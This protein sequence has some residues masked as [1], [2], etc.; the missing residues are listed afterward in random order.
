[1]TT[2]KMSHAQRQG[3]YWSALALIRLCHVFTCNCDRISCSLIKKKQGWLL[4][5]PPDFLKSTL[6][7][8]SCLLSFTTPAPEGV[9]YVE[10]YHPLVKGLARYILED[11]LSYTTE[12]IAARCGF[13]TT[14]AVQKRTTLLLIRLRH[15]LDSSKHTIETRNTTSLLAKECAVIGFTGS[16]SSPSWLTQ[17]EKAGGRAT[18][19]LPAINFL[20]LILQI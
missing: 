18:A 9:E 2:A 7:D 6:G 5:Q 20:F 1:M 14:N 4:S 15:L 11:A 16:P 13:T 3:K 12:P 10:R 17:L 19:L 8:K